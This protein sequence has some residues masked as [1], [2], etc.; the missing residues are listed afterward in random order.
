MFSRETKIAG[1]LFVLILACAGSWS[2]GARAACPETLA[3]ELRP[4]T[5]AKPVNLCERYAGK[6]LLVVNTASRCGYTPQYEGLERLARRYEARG[7]FVLGFPSNDFG[8][9]E[10]GNEKQIAEF[11]RVNYGVNFPMFE[12]IHVTGA[13][14]HPFYRNLSAL[15]GAPPK[16]N[17]HKYLIGRNGQIVASFPSRIEPEDAA[18]ID[19]IEK[20]LAR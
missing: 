11:C 13:A 17:F 7:M 19:A 3:Y 8:G 6:V 12:K 14:A 15:S 4:L 1:V 2:S 10:P 9:Q 16:W 18:L 20:Q 5:S